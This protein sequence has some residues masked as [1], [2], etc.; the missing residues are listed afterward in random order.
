MVGR[1]FALCLLGPGKHSRFSTGI[2][3]REELYNLQISEGTAN[4][5]L[6]IHGKNTE[7]KS[8]MGD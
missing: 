6:N 3:N 2:S 4:T 8:V 1:T 5:M 7:T